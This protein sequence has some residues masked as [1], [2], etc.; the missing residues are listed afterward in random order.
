MKRLTR[1]FA[2]KTAFIPYIMGGDP[3]LDITGEMLLRL[4]QAGAD[5]LELGMPFSDP[6][7]DGPVIQAAGQRAL[8][9]GT[10]LESIFALLESLQGKLQAPVVLMGYCNPVY[11]Y[12]KKRFAQRA[13]SVGVAGILVP[14]LPLDEDPEWCPLLESVGIAP[15]GMVS[16][17]MGAERLRT[18]T[19]RSRGFVYG[20]SLLGVT[21][22][23][24]GPRS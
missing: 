13:A 4:D 10:T 19:A 12:G 20:V 21:G 9:A 11:R 8:E 18:V 5:V 6:Q 22:D 1:A 23:S 3:S 24:R 2:N 14:D 15:I 17:N 16:P 7:A